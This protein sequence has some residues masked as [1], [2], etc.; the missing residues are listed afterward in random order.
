MINYQSIIKENK[1]LNWMS[2]DRQKALI[3]EIKNDPAFPIF[4]RCM[5]EIV[6]GNKPSIATL[7]DASMEIALTSDLTIDA[8][9][10]V[11]FSGVTQPQA[12]DFV[13]KNPDFQLIHT[14]PAG[15]M[16][17]MLSLFG[18]DNDLTA[19]EA[20]QP[21]YVLAARYAETAKGDITA[22]LDDPQPNKTFRS[23]EL[24]ILMANDAVTT[25][26]KTPKQD[27]QNLISAP[28][29][30]LKQQFNKAMQIFRK[31]PAAAIKAIAAKPKF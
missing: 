16:L 13:A 7:L 4:D 8:D 26:N 9:R 6:S 1:A 15:A 30:S 3:S 31:N 12:E 5:Q 29:T 23:V 11:Y 19:E 27:Y 2:D 10:A 20:Y 24:S 25:I 14:R 18:E 17:E 22:F 28:Q 21:W